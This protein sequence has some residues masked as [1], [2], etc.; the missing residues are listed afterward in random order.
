MKKITLC[1]VCFAFAFAT[2]GFAE[3]DE[4]D[5][6]L[7]ERFGVVP[8]DGGF[9]Q[10]GYW[11]WGSSIVKGDD[12]KYHMYVSRWPKTLKFHPGWM[13]A[14]EIVHAVS[15]TAVGPYEFSD[16]ALGKRHPQYWDGR[17]QHNPKVFK[18]GDTYV[19]FY[20]GSTHP[21]EE[22][23]E[24]PEEVTLGSKYS[25]V[26]RSNKRIGVATSKSPYGPWTRLDAP[27]LDTK[28]DTFYSFL[29]S[30]PTPVIHED[31]SV[32][33]IFKSRKYKDEFPYQSDM[34]L[35]VAKAP[36][37]TG[38][39]TVAM[40]EPIFSDTR[41]GVV[42]DPYLWNDETGYHMLAKDMRGVIGGKH[43]AGILAHSKDGLNWEI[44]KNPLAYTR[45]IKWDDG[46]EVEMGQLE[47]VQGLLE[48]GKLTHLSF[49]VM[50]GPGGFGNGKN[51]WN[52]VVPL[53]QAD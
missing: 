37:Y 48:D 2:L 8:V 24:R 10:E 7:K 30:N 20:M 13:V 38:P 29:T 34:M 18:H 9:R 25:I 39:Y 36:H 23:T 42:E 47:R 31:G 40:D 33:L 27:V 51:T 19:L 53:E 49:A 43:H 3:P 46:T 6:D 26:G 1:F 28:P 16:V 5:M 50:D 21:F 12:G 15:D 45:S 44:G 32:L 14:S 35:G 17:S 11:V 52:F 22:A 4:W 41:F